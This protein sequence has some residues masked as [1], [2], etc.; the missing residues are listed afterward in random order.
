MALHND[1]LPTE[2]IT[3][4]GEF[5][6]AHFSLEWVYH[7]KDYHEIST[8]YAL[9]DNYSLFAIMLFLVAV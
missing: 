9:P 6:S 5:R 3:L 8:E 1:K 2:I 7:I 4:K